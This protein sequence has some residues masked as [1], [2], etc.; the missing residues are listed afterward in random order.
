[1]NYQDGHTTE[2]L[3]T[4]FLRES[5][6]VLF[7]EYF[8]DPENCRFMSNPDNL[9]I[10]DL[11]KLVIN[12]QIKRYEDNKLGL[13]ALMLKDTDK[14]I[15]ICGLL[16]QEVDGNPEI[17]IGYHLLKRYWGNGYATEAARLFRDYGFQNNI[18]PHIVSMIDP[19]NEPSKKV[20]IR[21]GMTL[22]KEQAM[23]RGVPYNMFRITRK[24]WEKK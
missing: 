21:N 4:R 17:E 20:A 23:F 19:R 15:G 3:T 14:F 8:H 11:S 24:E 1:M 12:A 6:A 16:R 10:K 18:A 22:H 2:R 9:P 5:D 13:Q 7:E